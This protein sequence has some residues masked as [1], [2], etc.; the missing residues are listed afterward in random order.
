MERVSEVNDRKYFATGG[1]H[2]GISVGRHSFHM[3]ASFLFGYSQLA[4]R[5]GG[6][7]LAGWRD[8]LVARGG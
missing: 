8:W 7:G 5:H 3:V 6:S 2:S 4:L 1:R